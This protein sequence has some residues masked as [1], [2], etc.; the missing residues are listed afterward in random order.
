MREFEIKHEL[1]IILK[2]LFKK[3]K[4]LYN[5]IMDK[6]KEITESYDVE[7]YKNLRYDMKDSKRTHI[8]HFVL[9]FN[10]NK[11]LDFISFEYFNHHDSIY[12]KR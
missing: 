8:G 10:Y 12:K 7:H 6:I 4:I 3:N 11:K 2:K 9:I 5:Q 1:E